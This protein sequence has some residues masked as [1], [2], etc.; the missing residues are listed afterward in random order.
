MQRQE[1]NQRQLQIYSR[2]IQSEQKHIQNCCAPWQASINTPKMDGVK[3]LIHETEQNDQV[4]AL[5]PKHKFN[6]FV[7][8]GHN[9]ALPVVLQVYASR[10]RGKTRH[11][12]TVAKISKHLS[13]KGSWFSLHHL[14]LACDK[15][16][17]MMELPSPLGPEIS[18]PN[19]IPVKAFRC[20]PWKEADVKQTLIRGFLHF[21]C[22]ANE[23]CRF[24]VH[25]KTKAAA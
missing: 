15:G 9:K 17:G 3:N 21:F 5:I 24:K 16:C 4:K 18:Q 11:D 2:V 6:G 23:Q 25:Q 7:S 10:L 1:C 20:M 12:V 13:G 19:W 8:P 14:G 22:D